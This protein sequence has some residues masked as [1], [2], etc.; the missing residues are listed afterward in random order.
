M[1][2]IKLVILITYVQYSSNNA[3]SEIHY[4]LV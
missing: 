1:S 4:K 3:D 2:Q